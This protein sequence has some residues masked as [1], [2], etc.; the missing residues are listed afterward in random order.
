MAEVMKKLKKLNT[1]TIILQND[2]GKF[3]GVS[4]KDNYNSWCFAGGKCEDGET[5]EQCMIREFQEETGLTPTK[6]IL[7]DTREYVNQYSNPNTL[8]TVYCYEVYEYEGELHTEEYLKEKGEGMLKWVTPAHLLLG[9][10]GD[11]NRAILKE[12]YSLKTVWVVKEGESYE[13]EWDLGVFTTFEKACKYAEQYA[14]THN[15]RTPYRKYEQKHH[16]GYWV[17]EYGYLTVEEEVLDLD[18]V[19]E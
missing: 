12:R 7:L 3:L 13:G 11:Y 1:T 15:K 19:G 8:D 6:Y 4:R 14:E 17:Q 9:A 10:F 16:T 2:E 5:P 18:F